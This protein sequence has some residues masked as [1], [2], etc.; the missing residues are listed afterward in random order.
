MPIP[1]RTK[2]NAWQALHESFYRWRRERLLAQKWNRVR[3]THDIE[4]QIRRLKRKLSNVGRASTIKQL[5]KRMQAVAFVR[6]L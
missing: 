1:P 6:Y 5:Q 4:Q 3:Q 2:V